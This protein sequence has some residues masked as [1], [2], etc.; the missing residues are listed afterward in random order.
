MAA[1]G[2]DASTGGAA[3]SAATAAL[4]HLLL[5]VDPDEAY[6]AALRQY[7][8]ALA[9]LVIANAQARAALH[10]LQLCARQSTC[11]CIWLLGRLPCLVAVAR[12]F[13]FWSSAGPR[14]VVHSASPALRLRGHGPG[15][16]S[17]ACCFWRPHVSVLM[18]QW[19]TYLGQNHI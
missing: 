2:G 13:P 5:Y 6:R 10:L 3:D 11:C 14:L 9:Y 4:R 12:H 19:R 18:A 8:L 17:A 7:D 15:A 16:V 1:S